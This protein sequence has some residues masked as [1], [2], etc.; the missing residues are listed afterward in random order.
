LFV[1]KTEKSWYVVPGIMKKEEEIL[2][3]YQQESLEFYQD[4][5]LWRH[6][7]E[8]QFD[9]DSDFNYE[10]V[11]QRPEENA[12]DMIILEKED[13]KFFDDRKIIRFHLMPEGRDEIF[14]SNDDENIMIPY[15]YQAGSRSVSSSVTIPAGDQVVY[16]PN[17][18]PE[19]A[20]DELEI[21]RIETTAG[22]EEKYYVIK[23][24]R[25]I[26][27]PDKSP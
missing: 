8:L 4:D 15:A 22:S 2:M 27:P 11:L 1:T 10:I 25:T 14:E 3:N 6:H 19:F 7:W 9:I 18:D 21:A 5:G 20:G 12:R 26:K 24:L 16:K 17:R 23:L 13:V